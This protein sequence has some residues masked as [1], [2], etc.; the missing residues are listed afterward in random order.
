MG[1]FDPDVVRVKVLGRTERNQQVCEVYRV[2]QLT[3]SE[4]SRKKQK[5]PFRRETDKEDGHTGREP[6]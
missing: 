4:K 6:R 1:V 5:R 2:V 3:R